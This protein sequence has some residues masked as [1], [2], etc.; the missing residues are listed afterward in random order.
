VTAIEEVVA[1]APKECK[2]R[3]LQVPT[4]EL[5]EEPTTASSEA[6]SQAAEDAVAWPSVGGRVRVW[7]DEGAAWGLGTVTKVTK[8]KGRKKATGRLYVEYDDGDEGY[9]DFPEE[10][11]ELVEEGAKQE[12]KRTLKRAKGA[13]KE[14]P[15]EEEVP[16]AGRKKRGSAKAPAD[17]AAAKRP[18]RASRRT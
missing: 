4:E 18:A 12:G 17:D 1:K 2:K 3:A 9:C 13:K 6:S 7:F 16:A 5:A 8:P 14:E 15:P 11:V 10:G